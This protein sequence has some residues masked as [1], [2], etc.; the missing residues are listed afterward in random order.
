MASS[1]PAERRPEKLDRSRLGSDTAHLRE[2]FH[3]LRATDVISTVPES[4]GNLEKSRRGV[5]PKVVEAGFEGGLGLHPA[6]ARPLAGWAKA[7]QKHRLRG[8][9]AAAGP[10]RVSCPVVSGTRLTH[11]EVYLFAR[12]RGTKLLLLRRAGTE[13][14][15]GVWQPVTGRIEP[16]ERSVEAALREVREETGLTPRRWWRLEHVTSYIHPVSDELRVVALFAAQV[17]AR[18]RVRLSH[19]HDASRWVT[20]ASAAPL[21]LWDTQR[22][23]LAAL[24]S[25]VLRSARIAAALEI[26][27]K[28]ARRARGATVPRRRRG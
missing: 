22:A 16:R 4:A 11:I 19:E 5:N 3:K 25:Q 2:T 17:D 24:R 26:D 10:E 7:V 20:L 12:S 23:T 28:Q 27:I 9:L 15:A 1:I 13:S 18:A 14:L 6:A 21:V 8:P